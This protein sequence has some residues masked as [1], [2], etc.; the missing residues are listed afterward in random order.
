MI[1]S[2]LKLYLREHS[3]AVFAALFVGFIMVLPQIVFIF[4]TPNYEGLYMM[5]TDAEVHYLARMK[6]FVDTGSNGNPYLYEYKDIISPF[7]TISESILALPSVIF[8]ISVPDLNLLYKFFLPVIIFILVYTLLFQLLGDKKWSM[9]GGLAILLGNSLINIPDLLHVI[10][11]DT[12][13]SQFAIF[14]RPVNPEFSS[15][16]FFAYLNIL[17]LALKKRDWKY[18]AFLGIIFGFS[19]YVYLYSFTFIA[20]LNFVFILMFLFKKDY[21]ISKKFLLASALGL[22]LGAYEIYN[23]FLITSHPFYKELARI[24]EIGSSHLPI[25]SMAGFIATV[26]FIVFIKYKKGERGDFTLGLLFASWIVINQQII[27]GIVLQSGHYHWHFN[28][29]IYIIILFWLAYNIFLKFDNKKVN[30]FL[31]LL[32]IIFIFNAVFIQYSAY[33]NWNSEVSADQEIMP[34]IYWL[35]SNTTTG[36]II[37]ANSK[38][39]D[40]VPIFTEDYV[41]SSNYGNYYLV[42]EERRTY[43]SEVIIKDLLGFKKNYR[44]DYVFWDKEKDPNW[45]L[46]EMEYLKLLYSDNR[47]NIYD[48][49]V[50]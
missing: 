11:L 22:L 6:E 2:T 13:Y 36:S 35:E 17:F 43:N 44:L 45:G 21:N 3:L 25:F 34:A 26:L 29:P 24:S 38:N 41:A 31:I 8:P 15:I 48:F 46:N 5:K 14:S 4:K 12:I 47:I 23:I 40:L 18:F 20:A 28:T 42:P 32:S 19:F 49:K 33:K 30:I 50:L 1:I 7:N 16:I 10:R 37:L 39:S 9:V 27:T